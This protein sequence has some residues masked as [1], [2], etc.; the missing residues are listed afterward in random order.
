MA[1]WEQWREQQQRIVGESPLIRLSF[2]LLF[3]AERRGRRAVASREQKWKEWA[4]NLSMGA[5]EGGRI[6]ISQ[7]EWEEEQQNE[8]EKEEAWK[9]TLLFSYRG[10]KPA[11][12][13]PKVCRQA[14]S[15]GSQREIGTKKITSK[16][17]GC[18]MLGEV[19]SSCSV[20]WSKKE[21]R[22]SALAHCQDIFRA[23]S[24]GFSIFV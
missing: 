20:S 11:G 3:S 18:R 14:F 12:R 23:K 1:W 10:F 6:G 5:G 9:C 19:G 13:Y 22:I 24:L 8:E 17:L 7:R 2:L 4:W 16:M 21:L 15:N